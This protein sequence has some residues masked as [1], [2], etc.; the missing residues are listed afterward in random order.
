MNSESG[1]GPD[2][3]AGK[4][5][6]ELVIVVRRFAVAKTGGTIDLLSYVGNYAPERVKALTS[7]SQSR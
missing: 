6:R 3:L 7:R 1:T 4:G 5:V 2:A